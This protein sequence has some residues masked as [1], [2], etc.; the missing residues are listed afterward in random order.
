[1]TMI[2]KTTLW[3]IAVYLIWEASVQ[4]FDGD[5]NIRIDLLFI[6]PVLLILIL[7]SAWQYFRK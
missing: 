6:Y 1:M 5:A 4:Y 2:Q 7:V 3:F